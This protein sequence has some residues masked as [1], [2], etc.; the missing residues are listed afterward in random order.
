VLLPSGYQANHAAVQTLAAGAEQGGTGVRFLFDKLCH[1][2]LIDAVRGT[3]ARFRVFPH[4]RLEKLRRL[5]DD[6]EPGQIQVVVS[7]SI[8]SMD[9]D[10][11]D[12]EGLAALKQE[13]PFL[14]LLDEAHATG[15]YGPAGNGLAAE[16]GVQGIVDVSVI[17]LSKAIGCIG[18]AVCGSGTFCEA[19]VNYARAYLYSTALPASIAAA[20]DA[21]I[22]IM[23]HEPHRQER[24]RQLARRL[25]AALRDA[26]FT[27]PP[28]DA[29]IVP[30]VMG[31]ETAALEAA[32]KLMAEGLL[33]LPIRPPTVPRGTSRLRITLCCDHTDDEIAKLV[34]SIIGLAGR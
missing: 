33:V 18:G 24:V 30:I 9:G 28:G 17:T 3:G 31:T 19:L 2:S 25:R 22:G 1:A 20:A 21:A 13:R 34:R 26:Q 8:F 6:A 14:L 27:L 4:N 5:L 12:L 11:A 7:E 23:E 29:P 15:V 10:A 32:E 16:K